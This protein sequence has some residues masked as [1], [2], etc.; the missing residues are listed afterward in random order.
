MMSNC[1][2]D[3]KIIFLIVGVIG[4]L[5]QLPVHAQ[6]RNGLSNGSPG[7][8]PARLVECR[9]MIDHYLKEM[10]QYTSP[11][12]NRFYYMHLLITS[13]PK[14][15]APVSKASLDSRNIEVKVTA[16]KNRMMYESTYLS[17]FQDE[18]DVFT[19]IHPRHSIIQ[20]KANPGVGKGKEAMA[21][22]VVI[23]QQKLMQACTVQQCRDTLYEGKLTKIIELVPH[24]KAME[25]YHI[26]R[27]TYYYTPAEDRMRKQEIAYT[28]DYSMDRQIITYY[29]IDLDYQGK[30]P[31]SAYAQIFEGGNKHKKLRAAYRQY[32]IEQE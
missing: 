8:T 15:G 30:L 3:K 20:T 28:A 12:G 1:L 11:E 18:K 5:F 14:K 6:T 16:G 7:G 27:L 10:Q 19:V 26:K 13:L 24:A 23:G 9:K 29:T 4:W 32:K 22:N 25:M 21:N 17:V 2:I 31:K